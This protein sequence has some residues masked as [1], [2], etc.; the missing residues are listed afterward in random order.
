MTCSA[1]RDPAQ[2]GSGRA[3]GRDAAGSDETAPPRTNHLRD[4]GIARS[5]R[6]FDYLQ[7]M[8]LRSP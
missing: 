7:E 6:E 2:R 1:S 5:R 3:V 8:I 4:R